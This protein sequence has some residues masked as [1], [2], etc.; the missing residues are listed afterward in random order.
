MPN[1]V[2]PAV[3]PAVFS[4]V[5]VAMAFAGVT[6]AGETLWTKPA[7]GLR[8][9][10]NDAANFAPPTSPEHWTLLDGLL[11]PFTNDQIW[12]QRITPR[13][14]I[15]FGDLYAL[16]YQSSNPDHETTQ[17]TSI[18]FSRDKIHWRDSPANPI[19]AAL[20]QPWQGSRAMA[21][22]IAYDDEEDRWVLFFTGLGADHM[23]G[24]R[25]GGLA[26]SH[27]LVSWTL[28][29]EN[30]V[31]TSDDVDWTDWETDRVYVRGLKKFEGRWYAWVQ[32]NF[33]EDPRGYN[34]GVLTSED[35]I[36]WE[37][38]E[39]NPILDVGP[40][41]A[42]DSDQVLCGR[43]IRV[44][45]TWWLAYTNGARNQIGLAYSAKIDAEWRKAS[46]N[47]IIDFDDV[48]GVDGA[49]TPILTPMGKG[50]AIL[51]AAWLPEHPRQQAKLG[52]ATAHFDPALL[53]DMD[54]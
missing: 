10:N 45:D 5:F 13:D 29:G 7:E 27:D 35:L 20:E 44:G 4:V 37:S 15:E 49:E 32:A 50:W 47:P 17:G 9:V 22:A 53:P 30:P 46:G 11:E 19:F 2:S 26:Y 39:S 36:H 3:R 14:I 51:M 54:E 21:E 31:I 42:W 38:I 12:G 34:V 28:E 33:Q 40:E 18:M 8:G 41:G 1:R 23:P 43:P 48:V 25:A 6:A 24:I 16:V 52:V